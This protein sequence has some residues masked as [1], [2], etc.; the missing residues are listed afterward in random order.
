MQN[1][2]LYNYVI[3][4]KWLFQLNKLHKLTDWFYY[5]TYPHPVKFHLPARCHSM[6]SP[7]SVIPILYAI[8]PSSLL[9]T[10]VDSS[11]QPRVRLVLALIIFNTLATLALINTECIYTPIHLAAH[12]RANA[13]PQH[14]TS[15]A[16]RPGLAGSVTA[17]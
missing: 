16:V 14:I 6:V 17:R 9:L 10:R 1:F 13:H 12:E 7:K 11:R 2:N 8:R 15:Y 5:R 3:F 4:I